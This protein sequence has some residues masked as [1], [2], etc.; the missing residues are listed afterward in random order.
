MKFY[1]RSDD[2]V[3]NKKINKKQKNTFISEYDGKR[4]CAQLYVG[5]AWNGRNADAHENGSTT[6]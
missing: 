4:L 5:S 2:C 6:I 1:V 3:Y